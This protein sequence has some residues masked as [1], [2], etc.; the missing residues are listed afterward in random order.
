MH[1]PCLEDLDW[2]VGGA[3]GD[4]HDVVELLNQLDIHSPKADYDR[5]SKIGSIGTLEGVRDTISLD[6]F[7]KRAQHLNR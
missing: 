6:P 7:G 1:A 4:L 5:K 3:E 2:G